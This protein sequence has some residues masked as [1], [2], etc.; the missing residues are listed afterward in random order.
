MTPRSFSFTMPGAPQPKQRA[1]VTSRGTFTPAAT[2]RYE[3]SIRETAQVFVPRDWPME[4]E[5][6]LE[7]EFHLP[8]FMR[9]DLDNLGKAVSD[10]LEGA[11]FTND[12]LVSKVS[13]LRVY[14][15]SEPRTE[16]TVTYLGPK[17]SRKGA[18]KAS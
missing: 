7:C 9:S 16:V 5:Y 10:G 14:D 6:E 15:S 13:L 18:R 3:Q 17:R 8:G 2:R 1:R 11:A 12:R 4:G